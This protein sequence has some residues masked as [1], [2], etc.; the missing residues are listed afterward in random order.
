M[1][2]IRTLDEADLRGKRVPVAVW[3]VIEAGVQDGGGRARRQRR[4]SSA[5]SVS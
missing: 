1:V 3:Q 4:P 5:G 2:A